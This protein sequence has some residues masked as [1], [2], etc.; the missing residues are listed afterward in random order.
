MIRHDIKMDV[1][2]NRRAKKWTRREQ[3]GRV[4]WAFAMPLFR[5][6]PRLM[7]GW[8]RALLRTFGASVGRAVRIYPSA[9]IALP[10]NL[11]LGEDCSIG[12]R[13]ILYALGPIALGPRTTVS[14]YGHIC[15]GSHDWRDPALPLTK[16]PITVGADVW[17]AADAFIGPGVTIGDGAIIGARAVVVKDCPPNAILA[18]NP[19]RRIGTRSLPETRRPGQ[20]DAFEGPQ[21][22]HP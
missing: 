13:A 8:R 1:A 16:P 5:L 17:I 3:L 15:A 7:W 6:S 4:L 9:R 2:A 22:E 18:G 14:Q 19:A 12:D 10:W 20:S 11:R 21:Y